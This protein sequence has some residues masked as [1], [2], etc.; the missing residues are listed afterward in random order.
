MS[1]FLLVDLLGKTKVGDTNVSL[2]IE[3]NVLWF[4]ITTTTTRAMRM[5]QQ[6]ALLIG[7][8]QRRVE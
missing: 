6:N 2:R 7:S 5:C 8:E 4:Q 3:Q 1:A